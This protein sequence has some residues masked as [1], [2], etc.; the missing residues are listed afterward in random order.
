MRTF[1][2]GKCFENLYES[3]YC[4]WRR[5]IHY[6]YWS[7][8]FSRAMS[9]RRTLVRSIEEGDVRINASSP[10]D[11][12]GSAIM[13]MTVEHRR[14]HIFSFFIGLSIDRIY[15]RSLLTSLQIE[16]IFDPC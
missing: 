16:N 13:G 12:L 14:L 9:R 10:S 6:C 11:R 4:F 7:H 2:V 15:F 8:I 3:S 1:K 5:L